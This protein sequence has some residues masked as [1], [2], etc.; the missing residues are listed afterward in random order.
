MSHVLFCRVFDERN[1]MIYLSVI[2][3]SNV[4]DLIQETIIGSDNG[5]SLDRQQS[6]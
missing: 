3:T 4:F 1:D 6:I 5:L 2:L